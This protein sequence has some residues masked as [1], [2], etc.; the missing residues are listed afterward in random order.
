[1]GKNVFLDEMELKRL[2]TQGRLLSGYEQPIYQKIIA[3]RSGLTLLDVGCNNGWKT[4]ERFLNKDF[5]KII[6][7]DCLGSLVAQAKEEFE[8]EVFSFYT[9]DVTEENFAE[10]LRQIMY[11]ENVQ[12]FDVIHCSFILMHTRNPEDILKR[13]KEFLAPE[14]QLILIEADD[15]ESVM[16]PDEDGL[17]RKWVEILSTDLYA[18]NRNM[19]VE[20]PRLLSDSGYTDIKS[21]CTKVCSSGQEK[22]KK[23][24]MFEIFCSYLPEDLALL[25]EQNSSYEKEWEWVQKN[26]DKLRQRMT[27]DATAVSVGVRICTCAKRSDGV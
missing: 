27:D 15:T 11:K 8:D 2:V 19:G 17:F 16:S 10:N 9:C 5:E 20:L 7:I 18:G 13:L 4:K 26:F 12:A 6:G 21:E 25:K 14:G 1:M 22:Q 3:G 24:D 23:E